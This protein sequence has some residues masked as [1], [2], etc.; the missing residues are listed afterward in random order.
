[1]Q[2]SGIKQQLCHLLWRKRLAAEKKIEAISGIL[3]AVGFGSW[4][5]GNTDAR[6]GRG[7]SC[8]LRGVEERNVRRSTLPTD[9]RLTELPHRTTGLGDRTSKRHPSELRRSLTGRSPWQDGYR[10][11]MGAEM[12]WLGPLY[13]AWMLRGWPTV[14]RSTSPG[15]AGTRREEKTVGV[16]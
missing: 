6:R 2:R 14:P 12:A 8:E 15:V 9:I 5:F 3:L 10:T 1:M 11:A 4:S 16:K 7:A 13:Q